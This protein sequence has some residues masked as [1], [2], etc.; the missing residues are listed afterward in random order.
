MQALVIG[1]HPDDVEIGAA[2]LV[3]RLLT[4][5]VLVDIVVVSD[6]AHGSDRRAEAM[7]SASELG[8]APERVHFLGLPD[9]N[10]A[11]TSDA[12]DTLRMLCRDRGIVPNIV[13]T[14]TA[15]DS[16]QDH[17][18]VHAISRGAFRE[19]LLL[20][21]PVYLSSEPSDFHPE[22]FVE[23]ND[24]VAACKERSL[25]CHRSQVGR[26]NE[27]TMRS[28]ERAVG[29]RAGLGRAE[30]FEVIRQLGASDHIL[31]LLNDSPVHRFFHGLGGRTP[32]LL[33]GSSPRQAE[34]DGALYPMDVAY[35]GIDA[36]RRSLQ[37]LRFG[38]QQYRELASESHQSFTVA[39][40]CN[41]VLAGG[42]LGN[43]ITREF[44]NHGAD[45]AW[46]IDYTF[47]GDDT[48]IFAVDQR[49][50]HRINAEFDDRTAQLRSDFGVLSIVSNPYADELTVVSCAGIHGAATQALLL[51]IARPTDPD[52]IEL[53]RDYHRDGLAQGV[54]R[55]D[56]RTLEL[57]ERVA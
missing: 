15:A 20:L 24:Q 25:A 31:Q 37:S 34:S 36:V 17:R 40:A 53:H 41:A 38:H 43:R 30:T 27:A 48:D 26:L 33:V 9:G 18:A 5:D 23:L 42:P 46:K 14:H 2:G 32:W 45:I 1:A 39:R 57:V 51:A 22:L 3:Q 29:E 35:A 50:G 8:V 19:C 12:V 13:A 56:P 49:A 47:L 6:D 7:A 21:F 28:F 54:F 52:V 44:I 16:H 55:C 4:N 10:L 11:A